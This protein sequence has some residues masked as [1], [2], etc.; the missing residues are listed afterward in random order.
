MFKE[1]GLK[2]LTALMTKQ[3]VKDL[4]IYLLTTVSKET[5]NTIDDE[6]VKMIVEALEPVEV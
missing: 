2:L 3:F 6:I 4:V 5:D 1:V